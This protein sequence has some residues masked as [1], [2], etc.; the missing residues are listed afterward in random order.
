MCFVSRPM[1][2]VTFLLK[3]TT[4]QNG[5]LIFIGKETHSE[6]KIME[7]VKDFDENSFIN[8]GNHGNRR[9]FCV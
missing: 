4:P 5:L 3:T 9:G 7:I 6:T 2:I 8:N 1:K